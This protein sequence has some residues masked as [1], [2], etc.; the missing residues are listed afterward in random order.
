MKKSSV[1]LG[2]ILG[3][4]LVSVFVACSKDDD[5][6]HN[7]EC[8]VSHY[9]QT[10]TV[11]MGHGNKECQNLTFRDIVNHVGGDATDSSSY[12]WMCYDK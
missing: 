4:A 9:G 8:L 2:I 5:D 11:S 12:D 6:K 7:C 10:L 3:L 1:Y